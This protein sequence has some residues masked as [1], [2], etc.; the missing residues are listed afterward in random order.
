MERIPIIRPYIQYDDIAQDMEAIFNSGIL[1]KGKHGLAFRESFADYTGAQFV[2]L[3]TSATTALSL[4]LKIYGV[5]KGDEVAVA[6]FSFPASVNVIEDI[7]A[8]PIFIDVDP[9]TF[10]MDPQ[11]LISHI[12]RHTKAVIFVDSFGNASGL[13]EIK[14][15]CEQHK[16]PLIEDAAC[17]IGSSENNKRCGS[18]ADIACF[19]FHPRKLLTTGEGGAITTNHRDIANRIEIKLNHGAI[20][21]AER[22][23]DFVDFGYNYRMTEMQALMGISQLRKLDAIIEDRRRIK[24]K[25]VRALK[26]LGFYAQACAPNTE[27]NVQSVVFCVPEGVERNGLIQY[28]VSHNI[29]STLGTYSLSNCSFYK[30]KYQKPQ[31]TSLILE[32]NTITLPCYEDV[33]VDR[34]INVI[35]LFIN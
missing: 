4:A 32:E 22:K 24:D 7:G 34:V 29:E 28:L 27:H 12:T 25:Y 2:S 6:D 26:P 16:L 13:S 5:E 19:S 11:R 1:T 15:I 10:N 8:K 23:L 33:N 3:T 9:H 20:L 21:D 14:R 35:K 31:K 17:A 30:H 18:I